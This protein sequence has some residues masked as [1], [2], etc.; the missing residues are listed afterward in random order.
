MINY[1][2]WRIILPNMKDIGP[3]TSEEWDRRT[4]KPK[5]YMP[6]YYH[7]QDIKNKCVPIHLFYTFLWYNESNLG[8]FQKRFLLFQKNKNLKT[9]F[10]SPVNLS[11]QVV[12][13]L[14]IH[15]TRESHEP[16]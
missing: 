1:T 11:S 14:L 8:T 3:T 7:M 16:K 13:F 12:A 10:L 5:N 4:D 9:I 15:I 6:P 2:S